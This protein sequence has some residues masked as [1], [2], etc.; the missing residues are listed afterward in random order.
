M[1]DYFVTRDASDNIVALSR[2]R[3]TTSETSPELLRDGVWIPWPS[4]MEKLFDRDPHDT[5]SEEE[6]AE[7]AERLGGSL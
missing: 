4:L 7:I 5:V 2:I 6:A 1:T 3:R